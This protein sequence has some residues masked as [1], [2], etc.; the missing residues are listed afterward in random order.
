MHGPVE[1]KSLVYDN[2]SGAREIAQRALSFLQRSAMTSTASSPSALLDELADAAS[3]VLRSKPEMAQVFQT[4]NRF[5]LDAEGAEAGATDVGAFRIAL[6]NLLAE[7]AQHQTRQLEK[8][9]EHAQGLLRNG[10]VVLTHSRSTTVLAALKRA[11]SE[12]KLFD[13][14]V[15]ESRPMLEGRQT[16]RELGDE[17]IPVRFVVDAL[18]GTAVQGCDRV[19]LGADSITRDGV[20]NKIGSRL[21]ALAARDAGVPVTVLA[22]TGKAW[23]KK[24]DPNLSLLQGRMRDPKEVWDRPPYGVEVVNLY[25]DF[26]PFS[27]VESVV[28]EEGALAPVEYWNHVR[29]RGYSQRLQTA[30]HDELV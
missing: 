30:F 25:F 24:M 8:T 16:A 19:L 21:V 9:I 7:H 2:T 1:L 26:T 22:E 4:L 5:L 20:V 17:Q 15:A 29:T 23:V 27:L 3:K 11:K 18:V 14:I 10:G 13:V 12:G 6:V 28:C